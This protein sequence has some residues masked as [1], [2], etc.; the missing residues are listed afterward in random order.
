ME[1]LNIYLTKMQET[2]NKNII[3]SKLELDKLP[4]EEKNKLFKDKMREC[5]V[6]AT[7]KWEDV[8]RILHNESIWKSIKSFGEKRSLFS[9]FIRDCKTREREEQKL[10]KEKLKLKFRQMLEED[11]TLNSDSKFN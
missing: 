6:T 4:K 1:D 7:W 5:G 9:E 10:R 2:E 8:E 3:T 11:N